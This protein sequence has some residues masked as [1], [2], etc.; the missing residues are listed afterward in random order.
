MKGDIVDHREALQ[1]LAE[2]FENSQSK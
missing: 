1:R 2:Q